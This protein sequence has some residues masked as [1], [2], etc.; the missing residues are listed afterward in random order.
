MTKQEALYRF[1]V[2]IAD[3]SLILGHRLSEW[4]SKAP[5]LEEDIAITNIALDKIGQARYLFQYA[6]EVEG[7]G[8][9]EDD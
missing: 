3:N 5:V 8:K 2:R 1:L 6:C 7:K 9:T 4:C